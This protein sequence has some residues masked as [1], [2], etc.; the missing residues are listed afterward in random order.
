MMQGRS[1]YK[2]QPGGDKADILHFIMF[3]N[4]YLECVGEPQA[5]FKCPTKPKGAL[6][7]DFSL[8]IYVHFGL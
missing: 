3:K 8:Y 5:A 2:H 4:K 7:Y 1:L 6:Q